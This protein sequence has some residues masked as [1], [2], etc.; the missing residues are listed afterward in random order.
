VGAP[1]VVDGHVANEQRSG[2][3]LFRRLALATT[4][5]AGSAVAAAVVVAGGAAWVGVGLLSGFP[6]WWE[7]VASLGLP[8]LTLLMVVVIQHTQNHDARATHLK[9]DEL[10]RATQGATNRMMTVE[11][12][13]PDDLDRIRHAFREEAESAAPTDSGD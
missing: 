13:S 7:L 2:S 10:I 4:A 9:L 8:I 12:A 5:G 1:E 6:R 3:P 11:E